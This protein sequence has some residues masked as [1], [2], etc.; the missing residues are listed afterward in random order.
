MAASRT[1]CF[2][3]KGQQKKQTIIEHSIHVKHSLYATAAAA[4]ATATTTVLLQVMGTN[5]LKIS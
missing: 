3:I 4:A 2:I 1:A 5:Y